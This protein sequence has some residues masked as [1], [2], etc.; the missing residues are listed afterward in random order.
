MR[1]R[2]RGLE[3]IPA[4]GGGLILVNHQSF[5]DPLLVGLPLSRPIS[6]VARDNLFHIPVIGWILRKTYVMPINREAASTA[7]I[8]E[9]V[10]RI[11]HG[12][13]VG[14]FPEGTRSDTAE[15]GPFK[16]GFL[17]L[18]RRSNR[19]VYPVGIA[20]GNDVMPRGPLRL[21]PRRICV[22]FGT[23][24]ETDE[25]ERISAA[26]DAALIGELRE[27]VVRCAQQAADWKRELDG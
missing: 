3:H 17:A 8:R 7:S 26:G 25:L 2:V 27:R 11:R 12:F 6:F 19:P 5:L 23:P 10:G 22:V 13:L 14:I 4:A 21:R 9:A 15:V 20:G 16:P 1:Y 24:L 18:L